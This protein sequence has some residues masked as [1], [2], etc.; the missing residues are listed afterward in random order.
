VATEKAEKTE[1]ATPK[2]RED[3]R[4]KG[5]VAQSREL[6]SV[7]L[8]AVAVLL[9]GSGLG[10]HLATSI[11]WL[12]EVAWSS[13]TPTT[14][15]DFHALIL[16]NFQIAGAAILPLIALT[17][18]AGAATAVVQIGPL[19]SPE[20][21]KPRGDR[22]SLVQGFKRMADPDRLFD[23]GKALFKVTVVGLIG[24]W[25]VGGA[26]PRLVGLYG[27]PLES[28]LRELGGLAR[29]MTLYT[30]AFLAAMAAI[31]LVYQRWRHEHRLRM[32]K[33]EVRDE[34]KDREGNPQVRSRARA[35]QR[36]LTRSRMIEAVADASVVVTNPTH[37]AVALQYSPDLA[38]P[39]ILAKGRNHVAKRIREV[40]SAN[41][42]PIVENKPLA[43]LLHRTGQIGK[44]VPE[45]LFQ[46]VAEVLAYVYRLDPRRAH[47][48][49]HMQ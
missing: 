47:A 1:P 48:W 19:F 21:L 36:E 26:L 25:L 39:K 12:T 8:L 33:K 40:A 22:L 14:I 10:E 34:L 7:V 2:R 11:A 27:A 49:G 6:Q 38:A 30:L 28:G 46:A 35:L 42:I 17:T 29:E 23:L 15:G 9:L 18:L 3:A 20:A 31:D 13:R 37:F 4:R 16:T 32:S 41:R 45:A 24:Y 44:E 5:Q 43:Q